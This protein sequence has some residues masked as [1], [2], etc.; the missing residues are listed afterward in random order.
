MAVTS[1]TVTTNVVGKSNFYVNWSQVSQS[2]ANNQTTINWVAGIYTGTSGSHDSF[3]SNAVKIYSV[4]IDGVLVS[5]GGT[6]SNIRTAGNHDLLSGTSVINHNADGSK[7]FNISISAWTYP[8]SNYSGNVWFSLNNIPRQATVTNAIDF[9]D[10]QNPTI[11]Y[12][13]PAGNAVTSL[14]AYI[15]NDATGTGLIGLRDIPKTGNSYTFPLTD[16]ERNTLRNA[17]PNSN[18][19]RLR[20]AIRTNIGGNYYYSWVVKTMTI[21]NANP[22]IDDI[23]YLDTNTTTTDLTNDDQIIIQNLSTL[24]FKL[25]DIAA[26]KGATL[27]SLSVNINGNVKTTAYSGTSIASTSYNYNEVDVSSDT[28]AV[29]TITDS[30]GNKSNYNVPLTIWEYSQPTAII[31]I[32]RENNFYTESHLTVDANYS[33]LDNL[34]TIDIKYRIKKSSD[35]TWGNW[36][37]ISDNV[38][39]DFN[40]DNQFAWDLQV[41]LEDILGTVNNYTINN[42]L[43]VGTPLV[44]YDML[45]RK[46][47]INCFPVN[48]SFEVDGIDVSN[49][50][51][52]NEIVVGTW[53]NLDGTQQPIYRR[54]KYFTTTNQAQ[55]TWTPIF[56]ISDIK[57]IIAGRLGI[58][59]DSGATDYPWSAAWYDNLFR[60]NNGNV[61]YYGDRAHKV[62]YVYVEYTKT[63]D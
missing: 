53:T 38:Q 43:D 51:S 6:W 32:S 57:D 49:T 12:S 63:T 31:N 11:Y 7:S 48:G 46:V 19:L 33:S 15:E 26:Y 54:L 5:N 59:A 2:I 40:A 17:I 58:T 21:V 37:S 23:Q 18:S 4:Y 56:E 9:N 14:E 30:R 29:V 34:N 44:F 55:S 35:S 13:N 8:S 22:H 52:T 27:S 62:N 28:N 16:A 24:Q 50:Y 36:Q 41:S 25:Y 42:A 61:E 1:G 60:Y 45:N 3:Y 39:V 20:F 47:G 10:E